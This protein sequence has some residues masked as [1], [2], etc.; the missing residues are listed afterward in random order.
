MNIFLWII[1]STLGIIALYILLRIMSTAVF[2]SW[3]ENKIRYGMTENQNIQKED[4]K[5]ENG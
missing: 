3:F 4:K 1:I 5:E 2:T